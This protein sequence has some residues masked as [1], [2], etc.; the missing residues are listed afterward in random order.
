[1]LPKPKK[2]V[3]A[4][5]S[6]FFPKVPK[7]VP[8][9]AA[10]THPP[11]PRLSS[12]DLSVVSPNDEQPPSLTAQSPE[13]HAKSPPLLASGSMSSQLHALPSNDDD[14]M[15]AAAL[16][17]RLRKVALTLPS[18]VAEGTLEDKIAFFGSTPPQCN[19]NYEDQSK[20]VAAKLDEFVG[21]GI[22]DEEVVTFVRRGRL[23]ME[24]ICVWLSHFIVCYNVGRKILESR[25]SRFVEAM[26]RK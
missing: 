17:K 6:S 7:S 24:G 20:Y 25:L 8:T 16:L 9:G 11:S 21:W 18:S 22:S 13:F 19:P 14:Q 12:P 26:K 4:S 3:Y 15:N 5:I 1:M 10:T 2:T 23:G